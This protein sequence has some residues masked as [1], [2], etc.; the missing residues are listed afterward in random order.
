MGQ[1]LDEAAIERLL[2]FSD[3]MLAWNKRINLTAITDPQ[4]VVI[5][6]LL[7]SLSVLPFI[8]CTHVLDVG[9][10]GGLPGIVLSIARPELYVTSVDSRNKKVAFQRHAARALGLQHFQA[11]AQR[12]EGLRPEQ[13]FQQIISRA[14]AS[15][16]DFVQTSGG[17][18]AA[19]GQLLAM[20]GK[21]PL[22]E[23]SD[24]PSDWQVVKM[25][26]LLVPGMQA[27]RHLAVLEKRG[28]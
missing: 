16:S 3:E 11:I 10:G 6:H 24:M 9:S 25:A 27:E 26:R 13:P 28:D 7:D 4:Q 19:G 21:L 1:T 8:N 15:L 5:Q 17:H 20:K 22:A 12:V 18:L 23:Q 14:F 2:Q